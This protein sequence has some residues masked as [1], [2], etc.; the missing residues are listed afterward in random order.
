METFTCQRCGKIE[1]LPVSQQ[2]ILG[3]IMKNRTVF[4]SR[5]DV[6]GLCAEHRLDV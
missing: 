2:M 5:L 1:P 4:F 3:R 6:R